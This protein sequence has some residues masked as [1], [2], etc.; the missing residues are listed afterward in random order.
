MEGMVIKMK[1]TIEQKTAFAFAI[2]DINNNILNTLWVNRLKKECPELYDY[3][4]KKR[5]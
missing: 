1:L 4:F 3:A 5:V 2:Q